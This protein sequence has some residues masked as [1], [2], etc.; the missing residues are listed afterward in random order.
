MQKLVLM[1]FSLNRFH[2]NSFD[3][4][5]GPPIVVFALLV[6][7]HLP[8]IEFIYF[9]SSPNR[10][11]YILHLDAAILDFWSGGIFFHFEDRL[12]IFQILP[13]KWLCDGLPWMNL[14][15]Y[16]SSRWK[17]TIMPCVGYIGWHMNE[18]GGIYFWI[19]NLSFHQILWLK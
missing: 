8:Y 16:N 7:I 3:I 5:K 1:R 10:K 18:R 13:F 11:Y 12:L 15:K 6:I 2:S 4:K 9:L 14:Q 19:V 17:T